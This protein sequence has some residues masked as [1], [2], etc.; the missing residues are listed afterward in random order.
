TASQASLFDLCHRG[1]IQTSQFWNIFTE[2]LV[3]L[4]PEDETQT[5][6]S[7]PVFTAEDR[8]LMYR[9][10][11][12]HPFFLQIAAYHVFEARANKGQPEAAAIEERF[13]ADSQRHYAYAW[14]QLDEAERRILMAL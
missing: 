9:L 5:L 8:A 4:M 7:H 13:F 1:G 6:L 3:G 10:A 14:E 11:G 2:Q 12:P